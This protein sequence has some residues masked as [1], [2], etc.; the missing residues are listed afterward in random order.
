[1]G[2][3]YYA[4]PRVLVPDLYNVLQATAE[5]TITGV[6]LTVGNISEASNEVIADGY[7][8]DQSPSAGSWAIPG[9][10]VNISVSTGPA[11]QTINTSFTNSDGANDGYGIENFSLLY[12]S[13]IITGHYGS[14]TYTAWC[15][16][17]GVT[18]PQG[19]IINSAYIRF[20][21]DS[22]YSY[23]SPV[24]TKI[25]A[26]DV[27]NSSNPSLPENLYRSSATSPGTNGWYT[28]TAVTTWTVPTGAGQTPVNTPSLNGVVQ[29]I[30]DR[31]GWASN[32][33]ICFVF[34]N[35]GTSG[36]HAR[37]FRDFT[38]STYRP[39]LYVNY[40]YIP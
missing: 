25:S 24:Y 38:N 7:V 9:S 1:M 23:S 26:H 8:Y 17:T 12:N 13:W 11:Y 4:T 33:A 35:N 5:T 29:E 31:A 28:T 18:I 30:V 39:R 15:R 20:Y 14:S 40:S 16:F 36:D 3:V 22:T 32:N 10:P 34:R 37:Y 6:G 21:L 2:I 27:N 19:A